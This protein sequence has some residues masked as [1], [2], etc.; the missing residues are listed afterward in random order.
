MNFTFHPPSGAT[1]VSGHPTSTPIIVDPTSVPKVIRAVLCR[2][3]MQ[4][5]GRGSNPVGSRNPGVTG[6][7]CLHPEP[8]VKLLRHGLERLMIRRNRDRAVRGYAYFLVGDRI[9]IA[10][11]LV[12]DRIVIVLSCRRSHCDR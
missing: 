1:R 9:V 8:S 6:S 12:G 4:E 11:F 10:Y 7:P 3:E 2:M 5:R